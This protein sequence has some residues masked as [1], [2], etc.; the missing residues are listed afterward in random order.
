MIGNSPEL[1]LILGTSVPVSNNTDLR[2]YGWELSLGW[3]DMLK[4]RLSYGVK[5]VL[6]DSKSKV[7]RYTNNPT[8]SISNYVEGSYLAKSGDMKQLD[9]LKTDEEMRTHLEN[10]DKTYGAVNGNAPSTPLYGQNAFGS[11]WKAGDIMYKDVNGDGVIDWGSWTTDDSGD[12][13]IIGNST[14]RYQFGVDMDAAW[15]GFDLRVFF[16]GVLKRDYW[17]G[18]RYMFGT[19]GGTW[20][21]A[22][23]EEV[24]DYFRDENTWSVQNGYQSANL[25]AYLPRP[26]YGG[27]TK[28]TQTQTRYLQNASYVRLKNLQ[29]GYTIPTTL[30]S[31]TKIQKLR[32]FFSGEN[33]FTFTSLVKQFDPETIGTAK[34]NGY[35]LSQTFSM[36]LS[37]IF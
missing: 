32:I 25:N 21:N 36:G 24:G 18:S 1:P 3:R 26:L 37:L 33:L 27:N 7:T 20:A 35:P 29:V 6:F 11:D 13:K 8:N 17:I 19:P 12:S 14:R 28:N 10:L 15:K 9:W 4:N 5:L 2:T 34:G 23:I 22:G 31:K 30:L 16:Q